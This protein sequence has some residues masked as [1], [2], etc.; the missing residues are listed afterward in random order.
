METGEALVARGSGVVS[1]LFEPSE[2]PYNQLVVQITEGEALDGQMPHTLAV[3]Q[4]QFEGVSIGLNRVRTDI[5]LSR[6]G[7]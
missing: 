6:P 4:Q 7:R 3:G 2:E 1:L 5:A